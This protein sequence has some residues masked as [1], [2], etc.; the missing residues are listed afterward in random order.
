MRGHCWGNIIKESRFLF[1]KLSVIFCSLW[2]P[3]T[4]NKT[5]KYEWK[6]LKNYGLVMCVGASPKATP[7]YPSPNLANDAW[8]KQCTADPAG[9]GTRVGEK[10]HRARRHIV[11]IKI[12][13]FSTF[14]TSL[15]NKTCT[16]TLKRS[17]ESQHPI[18][19]PCTY[20]VGVTSKGR[21]YAVN[22]RG[23]GL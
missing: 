15:H 20:H 1:S 12:W 19:R 7:S 9:V 21:G 4:S 8:G 3:A 16:R 10:E 18:G 17:R 22:A 11:V 6:T 14:L 2:T 5:A 13:Q 23:P